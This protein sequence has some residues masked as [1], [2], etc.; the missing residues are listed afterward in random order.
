MGMYG[1]DIITDGALWFAVVAQPW[2]MVRDYQRLLD[3]DTMITDKIHELGIAWWYSRT[4][5]GN[6]IG[7]IRDFMDNEVGDEKIFED[8]TIE[9]DMKA[10]DILQVLVKLNKKHKNLIVLSSKANSEWTEDIE[11]NSTISIDLNTGYR[12][13]LKTDYSCARLWGKGAMK[14]SKSFSQFKKSIK[15]ITTNFIEKGPKQSLEKIKVASRRLKTRWQQISGKTDNDT[16]KKNLSDYEQREAELLSIQWVEKRTSNSLTWFLGGNPFRWV[17]ANI[18]EAKNK[19]PSII[20]SI[21]DGWEKL[22]SKALQWAK[23]KQDIKGEGKEW[24]NSPGIIDNI[25]SFFWLDQK[26]EVTKKIE[27]NVVATLTQILQDHDEQIKLQSLASTDDSIEK[28]SETLLSLRFL[29]N[30]IYEP[31]NQKTMYENIVRTCELQCSNL[32][33]TCR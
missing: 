18:E 20:N 25:K 30:V 15:N 13:K 31:D 5:D 26:S 17:L 27:K 33:W 8:V 24:N 9:D 7:S 1:R 12:E 2:P 3:V 10:K 11:K 21:K 23:V 22:T 16:Y 29:N 6:T 14:C 19:A 28:L 32:W 4:I